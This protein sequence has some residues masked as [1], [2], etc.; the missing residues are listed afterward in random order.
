MGTTQ[1]WMFVFCIFLYF[2]LLS[3][4]KSTGLYQVAGLTVLFG[5]REALVGCEQRP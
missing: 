1:D 2:N 4:V 3:C 5:G